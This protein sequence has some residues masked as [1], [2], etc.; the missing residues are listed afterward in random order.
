MVK[1]NCPATWTFF[2]LSTCRKPLCIHTFGQRVA[3]MGAFALGNFVFVVGK[4]QIDAAAMNVETFAQILPRH[5]RASSICQPHGRPRPH[6]RTE[7]PARRRRIRRLPQ[8][9]N[10]HGV[11]SCRARLP[12]GRRRSCHPANAAPACR[13]RPWTKHQNQHMAFGFIGMTRLRDNC[14][15]H[16]DH[17]ADSA[18]WR[19]ALI[20]WAANG[21]SAPPHLRYRCARF[22]PSVRGWKC[23]ARR[24]GR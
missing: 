21:S 5:R 9:E 22:L 10:P 20:H 23:R 13:N 1:K 6:S 3:A 16:G 18:R 17:L 4:H 24:R 2:S 15:D 11:L 12:P 19:A 14:F 7:T 8:H